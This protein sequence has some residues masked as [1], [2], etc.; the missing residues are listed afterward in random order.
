MLG[1]DSRP[2]IVGSDDASFKDPVIDFGICGVEFFNHQWELGIR[3]AK[4]MHTR[5]TSGSA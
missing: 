1:R 2:R 3:K 4:E 5:A